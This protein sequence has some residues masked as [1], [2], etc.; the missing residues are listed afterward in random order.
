ME[1]QAVAAGSPAVNAYSAMG[2][3]FPGILLQ[4]NEPGKRA[5]SQ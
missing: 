2:E 5:I 4:Q 3:S 1:K